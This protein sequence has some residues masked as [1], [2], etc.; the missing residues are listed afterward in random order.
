MRFPQGRCTFG[1][2]FQCAVPQNATSVAVLN[3]SCP[4]VPC[5]ELHGAD[6]PRAELAWP[7]RRVRLHEPGS[8]MRAYYT[9]PWDGMPAEPVVPDDVSVRAVHP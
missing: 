8:P 2:R 7:N 3:C 9:V 1:G 5:Q 6:V 4:T